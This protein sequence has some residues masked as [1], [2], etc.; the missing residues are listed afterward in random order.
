MTT[1]AARTT[2]S[3]AGPGFCLGLALG[4]FFDGILLHQILQWH[5]LL[6]NVDAARDMRVQ[7]LAD[8]L[9]HALMYVIAAAAL[10]QLWRRRA[11]LHSPEAARVLGGMALAGFGG[12]HIVDAVLSH[13]ITGIHRIKVD[14]PQPLL[15]DL[16]WFVVFGV[17]PALVGWWLWRRAPG[18]PGGGSPQSP[19]ARWGRQAAAGLGLAAVVAGAWSALPTGATDQVTVVF[20]PGVAPGQSF[21]ALARID[22]RVLWVDRSG[23][24]WAVSVPR[25]SAAL[26]LYRDG[27]LLVSQSSAALG[28]LGWIRVAAGVNDPASAPQQPRANAGRGQPSVLF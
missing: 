28:C 14:S 21:N 12:W 25:P 4:G 13:W 15:W 2:P 6:S 3:L 27:A 7:V 16:A 18:T 5:H 1:F 10:Y 23:G 8:G 11:A 26:A 17:V 19:S 22:A 9:F 20:A 24:L